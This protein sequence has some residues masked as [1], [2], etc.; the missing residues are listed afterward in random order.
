MARNNDGFPSWAT[1]LKDPV[2]DTEDPLL[3]Q[4]RK[5]GKSIAESWWTDLMRDV[6]A[7][8]AGGAAQYGVS[9]GFSAKQEAAA[10]TVGGAVNNGVQST[11]KK[12]ADMLRG[13]PNARP[14][15]AQIHE[16]IEARIRKEEAEREVMRMFGVPGY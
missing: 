9:Q 15:E 1:V 8:A 10:R 7:G 13:N 11:V 16:M 5:V 4:V 12:L 2:A 14:T 3:R 6:A